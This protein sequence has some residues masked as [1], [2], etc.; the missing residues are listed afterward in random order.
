MDR[1]PIVCGGNYRKPFD[2]CVPTF[3]GFVCGS[4]QLHE[5]RCDEVLCHFL[6]Q[7]DA[8]WL[9]AVE[10]QVRECL[11]NGLHSRQHEAILSL[12]IPLRQPF[13]IPD[14]TGLLVTEQIAMPLFRV[15]SK[16]VHLQI[17]RGQFQL[18]GG[19][20]YTKVDDP[21][22]Q[23]IGLMKK[24]L[25]DNAVIWSP[26]QRTQ[27][28]LQKGN[29]LCKLSVRDHHIKLHGNDSAHRASFVPNVFIHRVGTN[30]CR[31]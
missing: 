10:K 12:G 28:V 4:D 19:S 31:C 18:C 27:T 7:L 13:Q 6:R 14:V 16:S 26:L 21:L 22:G 3:G 25:A 23:F 15:D 11:L 29:A 24:I 1:V 20:G 5:S 8:E 9:L 30:D 2:A 17:D